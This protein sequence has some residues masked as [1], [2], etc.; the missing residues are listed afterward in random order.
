MYQDKLSAILLEENENKLITKNTNNIWVQYLIIMEKEGGVA[1]LISNIVVKKDAHVLFNKGTTVGGILVLPGRYNR[2]SWGWRYVRY[3][4]GHNKCKERC[5]LETTQ[6]EQYVL[7][8]GVCWKAQGRWKWGYG[9]EWYLSDIWVTYERYD[10]L[11]HMTPC[12][13]RGNACRWCKYG[14]TW[15]QNSFTESSKRIYVEVARR[16]MN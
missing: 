4:L 11:G 16:R 14:G 12:L 2:S 3:G 8:I 1:M 9:I 6:G 5:D 13:W 7:L 15:D 10:N